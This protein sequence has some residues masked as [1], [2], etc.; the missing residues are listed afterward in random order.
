MTRSLFNLAPLKKLWPWLSRPVVTPFKEPFHANLIQ[1]SDIF[2]TTSFNVVI[3]DNTYLIP[4]CITFRAI[5]VA[6]IRGVTPSN[7]SFM[8]GGRRY[9]GTIF[10]NITSSKDLYYH[11]LTNVGLSPAGA[12]QDNLFY[13]ISYP[14]YLYPDDCIHFEIPSLIAGDTLSEFTITGQIWEVF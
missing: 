7:V 6:G 11:L 13:P 5:T 3:P 1:Y 9:S 14:L 2:A 4:T 12:A 10:G 8:R